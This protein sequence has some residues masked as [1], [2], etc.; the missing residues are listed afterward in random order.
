MRHRKKKKTLDRG[1]SQRNSLINN[2]VNDL[3]FRERIIT[4]LAKARQTRILSEKLI[5]FSKKGDLNARRKLLKH[6]SEASCKKAIDVFGSRYKERKG[7]YTRIIKLKR[8]K[9]DRAQ[10]AVLELV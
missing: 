2:Q 5:T 8:R 9:G 7:G 10:I 6:V 4:T 1:K 3:F